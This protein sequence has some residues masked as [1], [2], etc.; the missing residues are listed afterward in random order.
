MSTSFNTYEK[1]TSVDWNGQCFVVTVRNEVG[2]NLY[3]YAYS[4]DG[5]TW[6]NAIL[7]SG[8]IPIQNPFVT[9]WMGDKF[10]VAGN[11]QA[12]GSVT[13]NTSALVPIYNGNTV[14]APLAGPTS[15]LVYDVD[16][17]LEYQHQL[18]FPRSTALAF[19]G[20]L[21]DTTKIAYSND[22]GTTWTASSNSNT[23]F[24]TSCNAAVWN[25]RRWVAG[26][27]GAGNTLA[28]SEDGGA[29]WTGRG[30]N[31][32]STACH[33]IDWSDTLGLFV[34]V[35]SGGNVFAT[36]QD[37]V[38]WL[39]TTAFS[40]LFTVGKDVKWNGSMW[41]AAGTPASGGNNKTLAYSY[42]GVTWN[43]PT[44]A[45]LFSISA[46]KVAWNG[47]LW[48]AVGED[49]TSVNYAT[50]QDGVN[51][52][53][54]TDASLSSFTMSSVF[55]D[56]ESV[57]FSTTGSYAVL[58]QGTEGAQLVKTD[59]SCNAAL[60]V[61]T[62]YLLAGNNG[63]VAVANGF[64]GTTANA[65]VSGITSIT[66]LA[67][68][69]PYRGIPSIRPLTV[70]C[71]QG[72][73]SLATS[74]DGVNWTGIHSGIF[75]TRANKAV[76]NGTLWVAVGAGVAWAAS[77]YDGIVWTPRDS[78][79]FTEAYDVAWNGSQFVAVGTG[80]NTIATSLNGI[81][82]NALPGSTAMFST[83][84]SSVDW[85]GATWMVYGSGGN[86]SAMTQTP[87]ITNSWVATNNLAIT[88]ASS[89]LALGS[90]TA[91][92]SSNQVS[93]AADNAFD[94]QFNASITEWYSGAGTYTASTGVYAGAVSTTYGPGS[95]TVAGEWLQV[96]VA[97]S[98][99]V[100]Y[101]YV[102]FRLASTT[103]IP[104]QWKLLG[105]TDGTAWN[106]VDSFTNTAASY[107]NN[108]W[109]YPFVAFPMNVYTNTASYNYYRLVFPQTY[110][111]TY[112]SVADFSLFLE[113]GASKTLDTK[114]KPIVLKNAVLHPTQL[115]SVDG[116]KL[117]IYQMTDLSGNAIRNLY[118]NGQYV[119]NVVYNAG[120]NLVTCSTFDGYNHV[121]GSSGGNI[122]IITNDNS[123]TSLNFDGSYNGTTINTGGL[124]AIYGAAFNRKFVVLG[125]TG[126]NVITYNTF[127]NG[128]T[129]TWLPTNAN[130]LFTQVNGLASN[131]GY[132]F[133]TPPNTLYL[134][135]TDKLS[136]VSPK[137]FN[138]AVTPET[139]IS[140]AQYPIS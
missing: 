135:N 17:N 133:V 77:S 79:I 38:Y 35:G 88:D 49:A 23:V 78:S 69:T 41:V 138:P 48:Y 40:G 105:S 18:V 99:V 6:T 118:I 64:N 5:I 55:A 21:A 70:A 83:A 54:A 98:V 127:L 39:G 110:G 43:T 126:G 25:G 82:W 30:I 124:T 14:L 139:S 36:S 56:S 74:V 8:N 129:P 27:T 63:N 116:T 26:G 108:T 10:I 50:S 136:L 100:K 4:Y 47:S 128:D 20:V 28:T 7:P 31:I 2:A 86:T 68:N 94:G 67:W 93:F 111:G 66:G 113:N 95:Q 57:I 119:N 114:I 125:G 140:F 34:A 42:D 52:T 60:N 132:G 117:N 75:T 102:V 92:S 122:S 32:F 137:A 90:Y 44:Q 134:R 106:L 81:S 97:A 45:D 24:S 130:N 91:T 51:W 76:W 89:A 87:A 123:T 46:N 121:V 115:L 65:T 120:G 107:P 72:T 15:T 29:T 58:P 101:Y 1:T 11:V 59:V 73:Y 12:N 112:V 109:K 71:G 37:G 62:N 85:T 84:A 131:S 22:Q 13:G 103:T 80:G 33:G 9:K 104:Q 19:G 61:K 16:A 3:S 53:M 96:Q